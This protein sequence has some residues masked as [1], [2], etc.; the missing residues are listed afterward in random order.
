MCVVDGVLMGELLFH[1]V[2]AYVFML[3]AYSFIIEPQ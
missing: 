3:H 1:A 2:L